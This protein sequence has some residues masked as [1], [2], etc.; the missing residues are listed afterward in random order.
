[1]AKIFYIVNLNNPFA[2]KKPTI[3]SLA[4][5]KIIRVYASQKFLRKKAITNSYI[6]SGKPVITIKTSIL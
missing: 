6:E 2:N 4:L 1:M 3:D 5:D